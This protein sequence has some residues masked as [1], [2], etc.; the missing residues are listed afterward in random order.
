MNP[1]CVRASMTTEPM[2]MTKPATATA[3]ALLTLLTLPLA[4]DA[5]PLPTPGLSFEKNLGQTDESVDFVARGRRYAATLHGGSYSMA[6]RTGGGGKLPRWTLSPIERFARPSATPWVISM[7]LIGANFEAAAEGLE[8]LAARSHYLRGKDPSEW[9]TD[10]PHYGRVRYQDVYPGIDIEYYGNSGAMEF[11]FIVRPGADPGLI[12]MDFEGAVGAEI[13]ADG[14]L[15]LRKGEHE[16]RHRKPLVYQT[17]S[18]QRTEIEGRYNL[19][20]DGTVTFRL[21]DYDAGLAVVIDPLVVGQTFGGGGWQETIGGSGDDR[22]NAVAI[23]PDGTVHVAGT[24]ESADVP[25]EGGWG[26]DP[27]GGPSDAYVAT[28]RP[29]GT[30]INAT[31]LGGGGRDQANGI[32]VDQNNVVGVIGTTNSPNFPTADGAVQPIF[33]GGPA[34]AFVTMFSPDG[35]ELVGSTYLGGPGLE[36]GSGIAL[37]NQGNGYFA[38]GSTFGPGFPVAEGAS[39]PDVMGEADAFVIKIDG[40][41]SRIMAS[42]LYGGSGMEISIGIAVGADGNPYIVGETDS[43]DLPVTGNAHQPQPGGGIDVFGAEFTEDLGDFNYSSYLGGPGDDRPNGIDLDPLGGVG[44][45]GGTTGGLP[46]TPNAPLPDFFGGPTDGFLV[47]LPIV[48]LPPGGPSASTR[49]PTN[50][51]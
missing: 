47:L 48:D 46:T 20:E 16:L 11:D 24:T 2:R 10:V 15:V 36:L 29:D 14:D 44:I 30:L 9:Q 21:S 45:G 51:W 7:Y 50:L 35:S 17:A 37:A 41:G 12:R 32:I 31:F 22:F 28:L 4:L 39:Q 34:D 33:G 42:T 8:P 25:T 40:M 43:P 49:T 38:T 13:D 19:E 18:G 1:L 3:A 6:L 5:G 23:G 26:K 27:Q